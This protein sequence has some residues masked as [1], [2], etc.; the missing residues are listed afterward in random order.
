VDRALRGNVAVISP[1]LD[2]AAFSLGAAIAR[3]T[4]AGTTVRIVT[5]LAGDP[6]ASFAPGAWDRAS[7]FTNAGEAVR[8]RTA[9][10]DEACAILG[11]S[12]VRLPYFDK[13]YDRGAPDADI[14]AS[15]LAAIEGCEIALLPGFPL[16]NEDHDWLTRLLLHAGVS[17]VRVGFYVEQPYA[18]R[19]KASP[20]PLAVA[21]S[22][23]WETLEAGPA[24]QFAK[25]RACRAYKSQ[26]ELL[27][28]LRALMAVLRYEAQRGGESLSWLDERG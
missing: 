14:V 15:V 18:A 2:D 4:K 5:V 21:A 19:M 20:T 26:L 27:G 3:S 28:G 16:A 9:E 17:G 25:L 7:G 1:H 11:A 22:G 24:E 13:Q 10:D 6:E 8:A 23:A 12:R